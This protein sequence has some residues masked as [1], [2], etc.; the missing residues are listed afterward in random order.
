M[1]TVVRDKGILGSVETGAEPAVLV[2]PKGKERI[3]PLFKAVNVL[4]KS[5][6]CVPMTEIGQIQSNRLSYL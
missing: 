2:Q 5:I 6:K 1:D 4:K 3:G